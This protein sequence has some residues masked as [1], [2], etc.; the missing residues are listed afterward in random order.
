MKYILVICFS[1]LLGINC[2]LFTSCKQKNPNVKVL[3]KW[4]NGNN[5]IVK[6]FINK[7]ENS[8]FNF[9]Y[10][11]NGT[12]KSKVKYIKGNLD[13]SAK[14]FDNEGFLNIEKKY[15][16]GILDA[17]YSYKLGKLSGPERIYHPNGQLWTERILLNGRP[18]AV[19]SNFD[20]AG[21]SMDPGTLQDG[22]GTIK[23]YDSKGNLLEV[24]SYREGKEVI[25]KEQNLIKN[26]E[27]MIK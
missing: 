7:A 24:K 11:S 4:E 13:G 6:E 10:Y 26:N 15:K 18:M 23:L 14:F 17:E 9:E 20:S 19:I 3:E 22:Y 12:L 25:N 21:K 2:S 8:Y 1:I 16:N 27:P 5:K